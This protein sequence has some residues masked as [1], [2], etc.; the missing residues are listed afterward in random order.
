MDN[1]INKIL[2]LENGAKYMVIDQCSY[3]RKT[4]F[5]LCRIDETGSLT[6]EVQIVEERENFV[7]EIDNQHTLNVLKDFFD[8]RLENW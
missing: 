6:E 5:L 1:K 2:T 7:Y 4:F 3:Q 8:R